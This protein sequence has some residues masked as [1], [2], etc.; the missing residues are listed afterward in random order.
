M[1]TTEKV[2]LLVSEQVP[3]FVREE[4]PKFIAFL[5][6][7][8][9]YMEQTGNP[10]SELQTLKNIFDVETSVD[11]FETNFFNTFATLFPIDAVVS[12]EI[13]IKNLLPFYLS[14]GNEK[15]FK[16]LFRLLFD[17]ELTITE[18]KNDVLRASDGK[19][20]IEK[21]IRIENNVYSKYTANGTNTKFHL[22]Q[23]V[24]VDDISVYVDEVI[25]TSG[26]IIK[27][28]LK[29]L[30]FDTAPTSNSVIKIYYDTFNYDVLKN[31]KITGL[32]SGASAIVE[33]IGQKVISTEDNYYELYVSDKTK[34]GNFTNGEDLAIDVL[35]NGYKVDIRLT[36]LSDLSTIRIDDGG[37]KYNVGDRV[38]IRGESN[39]QAYAIVDQTSGGTITS[40]KILNPGSGFNVGGTVSAVGYSPTAFSATINSIDSSGAN[41]AN[42]VSVNTD[43]IGSFNGSSH[44]A[45]TLISAADYG[46][47][48]VGTQNVTNTIASALTSNTFAVGSISALTITAATISTNI[49]PSFETTSPLVAGSVYLKDLGIIG[50]IQIND[51]GEGY[52]VGDSLLFSNPSMATNGRGA[53]GYVQTVDANGVITSVN[54]SGGLGYC[55]YDEWP[56]ITV[57]SSGGSGANLQVAGVLGDNESYSPIS[58]N[59]EI[60]QIL[61]IRLLDRGSGYLDTP[62]IDLSGSGNG[63]AR[64]NAILQNTFVE[65]SG[66]WTTSD[67]IISS[68]DRKL[69]S[70]VYYNNYSYLLTS[71]V[72]F[73]KYKKIFKE[74]IHPAG[75]SEFSEYTIDRTL[76]SANSS[77][78]FIGLSAEVPGRVN[79]TAGSIYISGINTLFN[80]ANTLGIL[81]IGSPISVNGEITFISSIISNTN[82]TTTSAFTYTANYQPLIVLTSNVESFSVSIETGIDKL[83]TED[84][85][86]IILE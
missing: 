31:R 84:D 30:V 46:F 42:I 85:Y 41:S 52:V 83:T 17:D 66:K 74:L 43:V 10:I 70:G 36:S 19:W 68:I 81:T 27:K 37:A 3:E 49:A 50:K 2:S 7:Y 54:V 58:S 15:A 5:E 67:G 62:V 56:S 11:D 72:E 51:G 61:S 24:G 35:D 40:M 22:V 55:F 39:R 45:N 75:F 60:G 26:F 53:T 6:A 29:D 64:A 34:V 59:T 18:P 73:S 13:L 1:S 38:V 16:F 32:T 28:E 79:V 86:I 78:T 65:F 21:A 8:Y 48:K 57:S 23:T 33:K 69:S 44:A 4:H 76:T 47:I 77:T 80:V 12:K 25:Q 71:R 63:A 14:K 82:L 9:E 20:I